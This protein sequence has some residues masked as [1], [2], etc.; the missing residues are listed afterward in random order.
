MSLDKERRKFFA[1]MFIMFI[2]IFILQFITILQ[3]AE[4]IL[5]LGVAALNVVIHLVVLI[6]V[7]RQ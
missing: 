1:S 7:R 6:L 4:N 3:V 5:V 2:I